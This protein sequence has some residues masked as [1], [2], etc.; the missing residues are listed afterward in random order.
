MD[1]LQTNSLFGQPWKDSVS[2]K[3]SEP[4]EDWGGVSCRFQGGN[5]NSSVIVA[6][7][8]FSQPR[9]NPL[10]ADLKESLLA[11]YTVDTIGDPPPLPSHVKCSETMTVTFAMAFYQV[12]FVSVLLLNSD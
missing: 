7:S 9:P 1:S 10:A 3:R 11:G 12:Y 2:S 4:Q 5:E 8:P 6:S